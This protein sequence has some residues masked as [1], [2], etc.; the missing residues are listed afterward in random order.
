M[1]CNGGGGCDCI[2]DYG[3]GGHILYPGFGRRD[4][5]KSFLLSPSIVISCFFV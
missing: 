4:R 3:V 5:L 1:G 2:F